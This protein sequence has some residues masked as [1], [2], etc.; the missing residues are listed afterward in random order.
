M[1]RSVIVSPCSPEEKFKYQR[2]TINLIPVIKYA[3][4]TVFYVKSHAFFYFLKTS[5]INNHRAPHEVLAA[6]NDDEQHCNYRQPIL[7]KNTY[8]LKILV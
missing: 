8:F 1:K 6:K 3:M 4:F 2:R 5:M 7:G